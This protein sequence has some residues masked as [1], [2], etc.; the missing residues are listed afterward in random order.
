MIRKHIDFD[1]W[2]G[3]DD[4]RATCEGKEARAEID[5]APF[6]QEME[7][8]ARTIQQNP[9][10]SGSKLGKRLYDA[11]FVEQVRDLMA[12]NLPQRGSKRGL[13]VRLRLPRCG[14]GG[15]GHPKGAGLARDPGSRQ[16]R[17]A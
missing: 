1:L 7:E 16:A 2:I 15:G 9:G 3:L 6:E 12:V 5:L 13:R 11:V 17:K 14:A 10:I 8:L 4:V